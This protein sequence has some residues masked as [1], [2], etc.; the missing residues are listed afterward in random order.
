[1][2]RFTLSLLRI[3]CFHI[4]CSPSLTHCPPLPHFLPP[5]YSTLLLTLHCCIY[6]LWLS[7]LGKPILVGEANYDPLG[8]GHADISIHDSWVCAAN[9]YIVA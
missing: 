7:G 1:M 6:S 3:Y 8:V 5:D 4:L 2:K 9:K